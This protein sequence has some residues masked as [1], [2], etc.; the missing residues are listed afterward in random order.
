MGLIPIVI[1][2]L[3]FS[4]LVLMVAYYSLKSARMS[5]NEA[6]LAWQ[7]HCRAASPEQQA[8]LKLL[9]K[10]NSMEQLQHFVEQ[11]R[12]LLGAFEKDSIRLRRQLLVAAQRYQYYQTHQPSKMLA[13]LM[14][15]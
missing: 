10:T 11:Y 1:W 6:L 12:Q 7:A 2:S 14:R 4:F 3:A 9:E 5:Y 15:I 13:R 8:W